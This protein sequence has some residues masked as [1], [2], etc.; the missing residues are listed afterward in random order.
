MGWGAKGF[1]TAKNLTK[2][3][4]WKITIE[5]EKGSVDFTVLKTHKEKHELVSK[6][7]IGTHLSAV[8]K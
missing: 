4:N 3:G 2:K 5:D 8:G 1:L 6:M 7:N